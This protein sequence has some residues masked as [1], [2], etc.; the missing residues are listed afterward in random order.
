MFRVVLDLCDPPEN[1]SRMIQAMQ[2]FWRV[3]DVHGEG[4][5]T[6]ATISLF[7]RDVAAALREGGFETPNTE[8]VK[9]RWWEQCTRPRF[10]IRGVR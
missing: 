2:Y 7:F 4:R 9:V 10:Q 1:F 8:D 5:L 6:V 3:L